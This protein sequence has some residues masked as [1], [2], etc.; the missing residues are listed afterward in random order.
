MTPCICAAGP[1]FGKV[2]A[3]FSFGAPIPKSH[4]RPETMRPSDF[5]PLTAT[6]C[7]STQVAVQW[8]PCETWNACHLWA[9]GSWLGLSFLLSGAT[10]RIMG[11]SK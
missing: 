2:L 6:A 1:G 11:L 4:P 10:W 3:R 8:M 5:A 9:D 7:Q